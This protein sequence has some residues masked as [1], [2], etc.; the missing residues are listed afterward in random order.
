[1]N[2][3]FTHSVVPLSEQDANF[4]ST[5][6]HIVLF[7]KHSHTSYYYYMH[8]RLRGASPR[9]RGY[10]VRVRVTYLILARAHIR[11]TLVKMDWKTLS[12]GAFAG[13]AAAGAIAVGYRLLKSGTE[14]HGDLRKSY[15]MN[16]PVSKYINSHN[17]EDAVLSRLRSVSVKHSGGRMTSDQ[18]VGGLLTLL[19]RSL[20]AKKVIDVGVFTGCSSFSLALGL[21]EGG[22]VIACDVSDEYASIGKP[23][24]IEGG[25][26]DKI[27]L[28]IQQATQTM[29]ELIDNGESGTFDLVF[30]DADKPSYPTYYEMAIELLRSGGIVL[31]DNA[32]WS[33][34]VANPDF[35]DV[36][37]DSIR[38]LNTRMKT[39]TRVEYVLL[40]IADGL[41]VAC[42]K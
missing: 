25:V 22:K 18:S 17:C 23:F 6:I 4:R 34:K 2:K 21:S 24:W 40:D 41:G 31:V 3:E 8:G 42:K 37:T 7:R 28:R 14:H 33:G 32:I 12:L 10:C 15:L 29:Q 9:S 1:M 26:A 13:V 39:D 36:A 38:T 27:D 5:D 20:V 30:I 35:Q 16:D 19:T 11:G